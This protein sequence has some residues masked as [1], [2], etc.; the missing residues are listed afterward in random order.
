MKRFLLVLIIILLVL[1][2]A[3]GEERK[4]TF[5]GTL[6][7][8]FFGYDTVYLTTGMVYQ[9]EVQRGMD[10]I[11]AADFGIHT[12]SGETGQVEADFL[13]PLRVGLH[14]PFEGDK[15]SFGFGTGLSPCF[16]F[17]QDEESAGFLMGPYISGTVRIKVHPVMSV[18]F[19]LQQDLLF[20]KPDWIYTGSRLLAGISF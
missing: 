18:F 10:F 19:Q 3:V 13:I 5:T 8:N 17:S 6:G 20:G 1:T 11:G 9:V 2:A 4:K 12:K 7:M 16:Q 14:F 15:V